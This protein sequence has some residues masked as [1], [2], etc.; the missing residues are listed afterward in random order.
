MSWDEFLV[1]LIDQAAL[2]AAN[3]DEID[4]RQRNAVN[5]WLWGIEARDW[6]ESS[7]Q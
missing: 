6:P 7:A 1:A 4:H 3:G 5:A 2:N